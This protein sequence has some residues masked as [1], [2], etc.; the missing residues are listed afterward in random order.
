MK[1]KD[2]PRSSRL[3]LTATG[4]TSKSGVPLTCTRT[5][6]EQSSLGSAS[7]DTL[8]MQAP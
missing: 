6:T 1:V 2:C 7:L 3:S 4:Y 5:P 8:V